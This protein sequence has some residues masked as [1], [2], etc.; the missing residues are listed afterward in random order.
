MV[1]TDLRFII[2]YRGSH[3]I[4]YLLIGSLF[5]SLPEISTKHKKIILKIGSLRNSS[6]G[7]TISIFTDAKLMRT[8]KNFKDHVK[9]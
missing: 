9:R 6:Q 3:N 8:T 7:Y 2:E 1:N 5:S 4:K